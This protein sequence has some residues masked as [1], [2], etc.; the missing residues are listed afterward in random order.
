MAEEEEEEETGSLCSKSW[1]DTEPVLRPVS[2]D[3]LFVSRLESDVDE[4]L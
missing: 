2:D 3:V 1:R 4:W